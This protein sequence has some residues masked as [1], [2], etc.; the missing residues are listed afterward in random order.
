MCLLVSPGAQPRALIL[1]H[2]V[3]AFLGVSWGHITKSLPEPLNHLLASAFAV[4][5]ITVLMMMTGTMQPSAAATTCLAAFHTYGEMKD[6]GFMF[7]VTP[8][9]LGPCVLVFLAWIL[10]N[11]IPWRSNYPLWL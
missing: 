1:T 3:G 10:N 4:P 5:M 7:L 8:A 11:L 6:Q 9:T 2:I